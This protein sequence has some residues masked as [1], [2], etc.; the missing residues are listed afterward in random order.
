M[1]K[2]LNPFWLRMVLNGIKSW[3][4]GYSFAL[5]CLIFNPSSL[6]TYRTNMMFWLKFAT[7]HSTKSLNHLKHWWTWERWQRICLDF[8]SCWKKI[9]IFT[10]QHA[11]KLK[12]SIRLK[13]IEQK[14][15]KK[16]LSLEKTLLFKTFI[17]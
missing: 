13:L 5:P 6:Q 11:L 4:F 9:T 14:N 12:K 2:L 16:V 10:L 8:N 15:N 1:M 3:L 17:I 7:T